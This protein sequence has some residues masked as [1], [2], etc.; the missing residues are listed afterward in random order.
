MSDHN[1]STP[2]S[3]KVLNLSPLSIPVVEPKQ[4]N[5]GKQKEEPNNNNALNSNNPHIT[6]EFDSDSEEEEDESD[7][8]E[9]GDMNGDILFEGDDNRSHCYIDLLDDESIKNLVNDS[10]SAVGVIPRTHQFDTC[11]KLIKDIVVNSYSLKK[12]GLGSNKN[13]LIQHAVGSGKSF[14]I[15]SLVCLLYRLQL[16]VAPQNNNSNSSKNHNNENLTN[17]SN[18]SINNT[19]NENRFTFDKII[20]L[21]DR[22]H[23]DFQLYASVEVF[24]KGNNLKGFYR[25][26]N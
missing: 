5:K 11:F 1:I 22:L 6:S 12:K 17:N 20:I 2:F 24:L 25:P 26:E 7:D 23:L 21:N 19:T 8:E 3:D 14:V 16:G 13:Y 9:E 18:N 10:W 4:K 15:A